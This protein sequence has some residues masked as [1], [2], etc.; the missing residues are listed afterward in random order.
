[1]L[2][3]V[4]RIVDLSGI[5]SHLTDL[6]SG[7]GRPSTKLELLA[8]MLL[9]GY[10]LGIWSELRLCAEVHLNLAYKW[11]CPFDLTDGIPSRYTICKN[12]CGRFHER[13]F[14]RQVFEMTIARCMQD[15]VVGGQDSAVNAS[16]ISADVKKDPAIPKIG[17]FEGLTPRRATQGARV[18][19]RSG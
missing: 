19:Q 5:R 4:D 9:V 1:M 15:Q 3:S 14:L 10:S 17:R 8:Q 6:Y 13:D 18:T 7:T 12:T 11:I 16:L 2:R